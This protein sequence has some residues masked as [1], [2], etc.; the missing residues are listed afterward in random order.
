MKSKFPPYVLENT[1]KVLP[2]DGSMVEWAREFGC[3]RKLIGDMLDGIQSSDTK[4]PLSEQ[5]R[6]SRKVSQDKAQG[7]TDTHPG[8]LYWELKPLFRALLKSRKEKRGLS[9]DNLAER[10]FQQMASELL[11]EDL[12]RKSFFQIQLI[13][14][15]CIQERVFQEFQNEITRRLDAIKFLTTHRP[16]LPQASEFDANK[17]FIKR[18]QVACQ[19][20]DTLLDRLIL[21][22]EPEEDISV[23]ALID[24]SLQVADIEAA[25]KRGATADDIIDLYNSLVAHRPHAEYGKYNDDPI[26]IKFD[27]PDES[28]TNALME[29]LDSVTTPKNRP[30]EPE[31]R[32]KIEHTYQNYLLASM[33]AEDKKQAESLLEDITAVKGFMWSK[34]EF[35][36]YEPQMREML[37]R[38]VKNVFEDLENLTRIDLAYRPEEAETLE[39]MVLMESL[40]NEYQHMRRHIHHAITLLLRSMISAY[41]MEGT[42]WE[43]KHCH[44]E[45]FCMFAIL[46]ANQSPNQVEKL[47]LLTQSMRAEYQKLAEANPDLPLGTAPENLP[48]DK[49]VAEYNRQVCPV[50]K[51]KEL[52]FETIKQRQ[53][54]L[55]MEDPFPKNAAMIDIL[56]YVSELIS[57][58]FVN[59]TAVPELSWQHATITAF[60]RKFADIVQ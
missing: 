6:L 2:I 20:L 52:D 19:A 55:G 43:E 17:A 36:E 23:D 51:A 11:N 29:T 54:T 14:N 47:E 33:P 27:I 34:R 15:H 57:V 59:E 18:I 3:S 42:S 12:T 37:Y 46:V 13:N 48:I 24:R 26:V 35:R 30:L 22:P 45:P 53:L 44:L 40:Q 21:I 1:W 32:E 28:I 10:T 31:I 4:K 7:G 49:F 8:K 16:N 25:D 9:G 50:I 39:T 41:L 38:E 60:Y 56:R 5:I 58:N